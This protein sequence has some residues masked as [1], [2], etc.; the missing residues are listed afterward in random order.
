[1]FLPETPSYQAWPGNKAEV[2]KMVHPI[3]LDTKIFKNQEL[4]E[5]NMG[6]LILAFYS[7]LTQIT[8]S[9]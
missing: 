4:T 3:I 7:P 5:N 1:M 2:E 9:K 6:K 8:D